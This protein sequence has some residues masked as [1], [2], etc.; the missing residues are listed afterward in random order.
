MTSTLTPISR[1]CSHG[2]TPLHRRLGAAESESRAGSV[3]HAVSFLSACYFSS[4]RPNSIPPS[5]TSYSLRALSLAFPL[6]CLTHSCLV[7]CPPP[8]SVN[9]T[10]FPVPTAPFPDHSLNPHRTQLTRKKQKTETPPP[11]QQ[12]TPPTASGATAPRSC[13]VTHRST[14]SSP[15][16]GNASGTTDSGKSCSRSG[17]TRLPCNFGMSIETRRT[18]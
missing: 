4:P 2:Q 13:R 18:G 8:A 11:S 5:D 3:E 16:N 1:S 6:L 14:T 17:R 9:T 15:R 10:H 12:P 7:Q